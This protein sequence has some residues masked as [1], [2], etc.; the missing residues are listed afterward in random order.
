M[1]Q[2]CP[3]SGTDRRGISFKSWDEQHAVTFVVFL[4]DL[5]TINKNAHGI[6]PALCEKISHQQVK[7]VK[8]QRALREGQDHRIEESSN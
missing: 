1:E 4:L 5:L 7:S 8:K 2:R 3:L 6:T